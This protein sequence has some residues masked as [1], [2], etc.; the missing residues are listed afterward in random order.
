MRQKQLQAIDRD[1][2]PSAEKLA[3]E[4]IDTFAVSLI[5]QAKIIAYREKADVVLSNHVREAH[6][7]MN[8]RQRLR[9]SHDMLLV[10]G[11]V[12]FGAFVPGVIGALLQVNQILLV[13]SVALGIVGVILMLRGLRR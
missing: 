4:Y 11:S 12:L 1:L 7:I 6:H 5:L 3:R 9:W 2:H 10:V 13:L 8:K